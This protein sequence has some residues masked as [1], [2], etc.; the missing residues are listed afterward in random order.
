M[1]LPIYFDHHST[2]PIDP[3]VLEAMLPTLKDTFGNASSRSHVFGWKAKK[4]VDR[5]RQQTASFVGAEPDEI[6]FTSGATEAINLAVKGAA[7]MYRDKGKHIVTCITEH[8]AVLDTCKALEWEGFEITYLPVQPD[9]RLNLEVLKKSIKPTTLLVAI[10]HANNEIGTI[11]PIEEIGKITR[12]KGVLFF[13]DATQSVGKI[14]FDVNKCNV[15]L[16][17]FSAHKIY[18]PKGE[19][20]LYVRSKKPHVRLEPLIDGGGHE[21]GFRSGTLNVSGIVG[22]GAACEQAG[23]LRKE[24][25]EKVSRLRNRLLEGLTKQL[26][27]VRVNGSME[28][29]LPNNLNMSFSY[30]EG[31]SLL[32]GLGEEIAVSSGSACSSASMEPSHVLKALGVGEDSAHASIRFGLGRFNTEEE[33]DYVIRRVVETVNMLRALSPLYEMET[34][35]IKR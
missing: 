8:R 30:V 28:Y 11:H 2:T 18:G 6:V 22:L 17:C 34:K 4:L 7:R 25:A 23:K 19:G 12:E 16:A 35:G 24:E 14:P 1:K 9:G 27:H 31:E 20:V 13:C 3:E 29:R 33:V 26:S 21:N 32:M 10:M 15:D 5:A